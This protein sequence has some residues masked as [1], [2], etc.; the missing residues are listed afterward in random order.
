MLVK[1]VAGHPRV[2]HVS[3]VM[4]RC[5]LHSVRPDRQRRRRRTEERQNVGQGMVH[6]S[7]A[8]IDFVRDY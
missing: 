7:W 2:V 6:A 8:D 4:P 3:R 5:K 1:I